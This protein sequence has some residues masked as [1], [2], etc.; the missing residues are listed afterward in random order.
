MVDLRP[1][2]ISAG[3]ATMAEGIKAEVK[4]PEGPARSL[5]TS[6]SSTMFPPKDLHLI[7][8]PSTSTSSANHLHAYHLQRDHLLCSQPPSVCLHCL[9]VGWIVG[10][11]CLAVWSVGIKRGLLL[12]RPLVSF[13][14][15]IV[16][17]GR[18]SCLPSCPRRTKAG[19]AGHYTWERKK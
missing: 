17:T 13:D 11:G 1:C 19:R 5:Q 6:V 8:W 14:L 10:Y 18:I 9:L 7:S 4:S 16:M 12:L 15:H 3:Q 2:H